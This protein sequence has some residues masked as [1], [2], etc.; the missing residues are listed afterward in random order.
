MAKKYFW[1]SD[2]LQIYAAVGIEWRKYVLYKY[3]CVY[4]CVF[5]I[6]IYA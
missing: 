2:R 4:V 6:I 1:N 3:I 5:I